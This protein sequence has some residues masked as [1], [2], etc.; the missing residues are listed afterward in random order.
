MLGA[1]SV[2]YAATAQMNAQSEAALMQQRFFQ[3]NIKNNAYLLYQPA[4]KH[5]ECIGCGAPLVSLHK[6][7][8]C[9]RSA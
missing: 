1:L 4:K 5:V 9:K 2:I 6:C 8:Y 3:E 7:E